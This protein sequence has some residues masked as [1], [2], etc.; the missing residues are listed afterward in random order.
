[1]AIGMVLMETGGHDNPSLVAVNG[2]LQAISTGVFMYA[3]FF[4][5][6]RDELHGNTSLARLCFM[7]LGFTVLALMGLIPE[8]DLFQEWEPG[9]AATPGNMTVTAVTTEWPLT[10]VNGTDLI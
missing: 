9:L 1:M 4:E 10:L 5:I 3:T 7:L 8:E 2:V 6:L